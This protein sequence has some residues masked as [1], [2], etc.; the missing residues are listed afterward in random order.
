VFWEV[1]VCSFGTSIGRGICCSLVR[2]F[3][4]ASGHERQIV[5]QRRHKKAA[6]V[7]STPS[8]L[9]DISLHFSGAFQAEADRCAKAP[10]KN[11]QTLSA[12]RMA[13]GVSLCID[14]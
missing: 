5:R 13:S 7:S 1:R 10:S 4:H 12:M 2:L 11:A 9:A 8:R 3:H 6:K 14:A